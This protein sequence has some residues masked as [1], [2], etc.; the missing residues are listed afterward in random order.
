[1]KERLSSLESTA[2]ETLLALNNL[3]RYIPEFG[4]QQSPNE[5]NVN[6]S[7]S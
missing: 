5:E 4:S 7:Y 1:M 3:T 2:A 6:N